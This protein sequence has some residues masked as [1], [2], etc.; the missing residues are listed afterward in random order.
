MTASVEN[1]R[2]C[3]VENNGNVSGF[4]KGLYLC[5]EVIERHGGKIWADSEIAK[6]ATFFFKLQLEQKL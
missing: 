2:Y 3:R 6:G 1:W 4:G 5:A